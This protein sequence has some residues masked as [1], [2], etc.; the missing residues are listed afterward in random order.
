MAKV[1]ALFE[2]KD[3]ISPELV[4]IQRGVH[5]TRQSFGGFDRSYRRTA[6]QFARETERMQREI[7]S[8]RSELSR[9]GS[10]REKPRVE[11]DNQA[12]QEIADIRQQLTGLAGLT[13]G[14]AIGTNVDGAMTEIQAAF[15][16]RALYAAK[17][18]T[19]EEMQLFDQKAKELLMS[20]PFLNRAEAMGII[21][22]SEQFN[23]KN[24]GSYAERA[25]MLGVTTRFSPEEHL[26]M[27]AV[28]RENTGVDDANR[29]GN[30]IQHMNNTMKDFKDEFVD[31]IIEYTVQTG[32]FLDTPE[33]MAAL[34]EEIGKMNIWSD[35]KALDA[36]KE[37]T[38]KL[39]NQ[40]DLTNV[41]KTGYETQGMDAA[42]ALE[43]AAKEAAE[44]NKLLNSGDKTDTQI[45]MGRL[46][47]SMATIQDKNVQKQ[48]LNELGAGPGEDLGKHFAPL[49][50]VA[51]KLATGEIKPQIG[52]ELDKAYK[53]ATANNP[54]F[55]Y[56]KAQN[57]A[58]QAVLDFGAKV[59]QD[60]TPALTGLS[61]AA[62]WLAEKFNA[63]PNGVRY[64][65]EMAAA[66]MALAA[67]GYMLIRSATA[68]L[69]AARALESAARSMAGETDL[70]IGGTGGKKRKWWNPKTWKKDAPEPP[71]RKWLSS[72]E[73]RK[74][75]LDG[76]D[77]VKESTKKGLLGGL[78]DRLSGMLPNKETL[79]D[80]GGKAWAT[81][82]IGKYGGAVFRKLPL[83]GALFGAG[84]ILTADN[85]LEAAGRFGAES[86]G[87]WGGAAA[88]AAIGSVIPGLGTAVGGIVG[89]I[90]GA[91]GGGALFDKV[92]AWWNDAP[93]TPPPPTKPGMI[94]PIPREELDK[95]RPATPVAGPPIPPVS[96]VG[97]TA[98][99]PKL[100]SV[101]VSSI[102]I[103]LKAEGVLQDVA[104]MLRLLRDPAVSNEVKRIV[105]KA[106]IDALET[107]GG[108]AGGGAPA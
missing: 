70:D 72:E 14:I 38:L 73:A 106:F 93:A 99:K 25:A 17:G 84:Q 83:I 60:V 96:P 65:L 23:G 2:A 76:P 78:K 104:G 63:M 28:M 75:A 50:E 48:I 49:L 88:G 101:T 41:L 107:R 30:A 43:K 31:S 52:N 56:Q 37:T 55:E 45:A 74:A 67:G 91:L 5:N 57:Q 36:L 40:G 13:A 6:S 8:L 82:T 80:F 3:R 86:L 59:A 18:K 51:G 100:V 61:K 34:V 9:L 4:K 44:I 1:T 81:E 71:V 103:T 15:K 66:T 102:P 21:S 24:A 77:P 108:V 19:Q 7:H 87:G 42:K 47:M 26:K 94:K 35:D 97:K 85:K 92:K 69:R 16:E 98:E 29:L 54:L 89:G 95:L 90:A 53:A 68:Q 105:E 10:M 64:G 62:E 58:K 11:I 46:M 22:K 79:K 20:N 33:K 27:M 12:S 32:K 39:T